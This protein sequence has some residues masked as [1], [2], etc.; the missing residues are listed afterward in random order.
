MD[1]AR[2]PRG[3]QPGAEADGA[4]PA[5]SILRRFVWSLCVVIVA[6]TQTP[7]AE[8][9]DLG[10]ARHEREAEAHARSAEEHAAEFDPRA[11]A[12]GCFRGAGRRA[13]RSAI[14][15][16]SVRNPTAVHR[17]AAEAHRRRAA[18]H[19]AASAALRE[20]EAR[21][22]NGVAPD[23]RDMS[24]FEHAEDVVSVRPLL[25]ASVTPGRGYRGGHTVGAVVTFRAVEG[26]TVESLQRVIDCHLARNASLGHVVPEQSNCPLVP[27]GVRAHVF[28][29][30]EA[31][32]VAIRS[33]DRRTA[34][35]VLLRARRLIS[36][37]GPE[38]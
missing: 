29:A 22:C 33:R 17:S 21:A 2:S 26:M 7:G 36:A 5:F 32:A 14:C 23:D 8:P 31:F 18:E 19:R 30:G 37:P 28:S 10:V 20:A 9:H 11:G 34:R 25:S 6:C 27:R 16:T 4:G 12:H 24:P 38:R 35:E 3:S 15:W 13:E 1:V